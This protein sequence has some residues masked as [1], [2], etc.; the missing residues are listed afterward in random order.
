M[1]VCVADLTPFGVP[2]GAKLF[3]CEVMLGPCLLYFGLVLVTLDLVGVVQL[4][5]GY[6]VVIAI[7]GVPGVTIVPWGCGVML[8]PFWLVNSRQVQLLLCFIVVSAA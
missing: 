2:G 4:S 5:S 3:W 7:F 8:G 6:L 1:D